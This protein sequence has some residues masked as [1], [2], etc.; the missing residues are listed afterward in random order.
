MEM[1]SRHEVQARK[2]NDAAVLHQKT[3]SPRHQRTDHH[4]H[5]ER[6]QQR[7]R[8]HESGGRDSGPILSSSSHSTS[9]LAE[10]Y[11]GGGSRV[12]RTAGITGLLTVNEQSAQQQQQQTP[13]SPAT[14]ASAG[15][16]RSHNQKQS[17]TDPA[18]AAV[19]SPKQNHGHHKAHSHDHK[20]A[21]KPAVSAPT[22]TEG[23][24]L[25]GNNYHLSCSKTLLVIYLYLQIIY[26][27][28]HSLGDARKETNA[29]QRRAECTL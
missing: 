7:R 3:R 24:L 6:K 23:W 26:R 25:Y 17:R 10:Y 11:G 12:T 20:H 28:A 2:T 1:A 5:A 4:S 22:S 15:S 14:S 29:K 16:Q 18:T 9:T 21:A 8:S 19:A 13:R 27:F